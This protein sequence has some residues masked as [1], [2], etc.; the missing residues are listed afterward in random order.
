MV[1]SLEEAKRYEQAHEAL[2]AQTPH[3]QTA[4]KSYIA[5]RNVIITALNFGIQSRLAPL[6]LSPLL[7]PYHDGS[8]SEANPYLTYIE[9]KRK[10]YDNTER[11]GKTEYIKQNIAYLEEQHSYMLQADKF[12]TYSNLFVLYILQKDYQTAQE[13]LEKLLPLSDILENTV[14][15]ALLTLSRLNML[16]FC[17][18][19]FQ[20]ETAARILKSVQNHLA[21]NP[22]QLRIRFFQI[23]YA[24]FIKD[25][26]TVLQT[27]Q[28]IQAQE[29]DRLTKFYLKLIECIL[30]FE[31]ADYEMTA[32]WL[33]NLSQNMRYNDFQDESLDKFLGVFRKAV[34]EKNESIKKNM[35]LSEALQA[36]IKTSYDNWAMNGFYSLPIAWLYHRTAL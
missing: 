14:S 2:Q 10:I 3:Y 7:P 24:I 28:I 25:K 13:I 16:S 18:K 35:P 20:F 9:R 21:E 4:L 5:E 27:I 33:H 19:S 34:K 31:A 15:R 30:F 23:W 12:S 32:T 22:Y 8:S 36:E 29:I 6:E 1:D 17:L 26:T 11:S